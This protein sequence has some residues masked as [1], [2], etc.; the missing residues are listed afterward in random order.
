MIW[1]LGR[2]LCL[3]LL[4]T[5]MTS[6][7]SQSNKYTTYSTNITGNF[8]LGEGTFVDIQEDWNGFMWIAT[9]DGLF[10]FDG[11]E[12][13]RYDDTGK[14]PVIPH[15]YI[16]DLYVDHEDRVLWIGTR[17]GLSKYNPATE[18]SEHYLADFQD[19]TSIADNL[20]RRIL[21]DKNG[22]I[23][24][25]CYTRGLSRYRSESNDFQSYYFH[26]P[27]IESL[28]RDYP[29]INATRLNSFFVMT[30]DP[31]NDDELWLGSGLGLIRFDQSTGQFDWLGHP[32]NI[33][34]GK[35]TYFGQSISALHSSKNSL[36]VGLSHSLYLLNED[37]VVTNYI[38]EFE[39]D[40]KELRGI[41]KILNG[42]EN[43][44]YI[45]FRNGSSLL[46]LEEEQLDEVWV[47]DLSLGSRNGIY[48]VDRS[49]K[50]WVYSSGQLVLYHNSDSFTKGYMLPEK[51]RA[52]P[53]VVIQIDDH[54][55][56]MLTSD[57]H[58]YHLFDLSSRKWRT[59]D[60]VVRNKSPLPQSWNSG[61]IS[62][63]GQIYLLSEERIYTFS[64]RDGGLSLLD[65]ELDLEQADLLQVITD[66]NNNLWI[67]SMNSGLFHVNVPSGTIQQYREIFNSKHHLSLYAWMTDLY[68]DRDQ[69]IWVRLSRSFAV[70]DPATNKVS[71]FPVESTNH[72]TF[73]YVRNF[74]EDQDGNI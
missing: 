49:G 57:P 13:L 23:W 12:T 48:Q 45:T 43:E 5:L 46:N 63:D 61:T 10:R 26:L 62:E 2:L 64:Q 65:V 47:D 34:Q 72:N 17:G 9:T 38:D 67:S 66:S 32:S 24:I 53:K 1:R 19:S 74:A 54:S 68:E 44:V 58:Q 42:E 60:F 3:L 33:E 22:Q 41:R 31:W 40:G 39:Y 71:H 28:A 35:E 55:I 15:S 11:T 4:S 25:S 59:N 37:D 20:A 6:L 56:L 52:E 30:T 51:V 50:V 18:S 7:Y 69:R 29:S 8:D 70:I 36:I 14:D 27:D 16:Y 21:K 73:Q